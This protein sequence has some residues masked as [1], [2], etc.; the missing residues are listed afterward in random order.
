MG[1]RGSDRS[2]EVLTRPDSSILMTMNSFLLW[3][4]ATN[5]PALSISKTHV[6]NPLFQEKNKLSTL[7]SHHSPSSAPKWAIYKRREKKK[8]IASNNPLTENPNQIN[9]SFSLSPDSLGENVICFTDD[10]SAAAS[11]MMLVSAESIWWRRRCK[12]KKRN[13]Q[14]VTECQTIPERESRRVEIYTRGKTR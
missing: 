14:W 10:D 8:I 7:I 5:S 4:P 2:W 12:Q 6:K 9:H 13:S 1:S 3:E 11:W